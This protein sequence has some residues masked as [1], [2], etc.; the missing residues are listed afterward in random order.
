[1]GVMLDSY[2]A[3]ELDPATRRQLA[4]YVERWR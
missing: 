1:M 3:P 2:V 4:E